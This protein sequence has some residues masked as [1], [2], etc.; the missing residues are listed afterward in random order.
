M[1]YYAFLANKH[2]VVK[3]L[4]FFSPPNDPPRGT[5][6]IYKGVANAKTIACWKEKLRRKNMTPI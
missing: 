4:A 3:H 6:G 1:S 5:N 2:V